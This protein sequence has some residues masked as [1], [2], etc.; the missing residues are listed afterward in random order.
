[1]RRLC[2]LFVFIVASMSAAP[3]WAEEEPIFAGIWAAKDPGG[4]GAFFYD[5]S[6]DGLVSHWKE[7]GQQNQYLADVEVYQRGGK[8]TF[9]AV[10]RVG[11]GNGALLLAPWKDF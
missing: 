2:A 5:Q 3:V 11:P 4:T 7:L 9:A 1:M 10:W 8:R 6:W